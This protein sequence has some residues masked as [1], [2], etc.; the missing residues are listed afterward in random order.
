M[1]KFISTLLYCVCFLL[2]IQNV[3]A[4]GIEFKTELLSDGITYK[5]SMKPSTTWTAPNNNTLGAQVTIVVQTGGFQMDNLTSINGVWDKL[6]TIV[7]PT[8]RP[9]KDYIVVYLTTS[10]ALPY[11]ANTEIP[12][13]TFQNT[14][15]CT[16]ILELIHNASD[17]FMP[18]NSQ[19]FNVGNYIS[20]RGGGGSS[21]NLWTGN[22]GA[23]ADCRPCKIEYKLTP[24]STG[25]YQV[26]MIPKTTWLGALAITATQQVTI[27]AP[28]G[29]FQAANLTSLVAGVNYSQSSRFNAPS[30]N[31]TKDYLLFT[32]NN[33]GTT[34]L[35]YT[36]NVEVPLF[37]FT[38]S[39]SCTSG[40]IELMNNLSDP[41]RL[42]NS[43][44]ANV[45]QQ[46]TTVGGGVDMPICLNTSYTAP[47]NKPP[48]TGTCLISNEIHMTI[49]PK[50]EV[51]VSV[52]TNTVCVGGNVTL[53]AT[54]TGG[55]GCSVQWQSSPQAPNNWIDVPSATAN[56]YTTP[57]LS[58]TLKYRTRLICSG[59]GC[60]N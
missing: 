35:T 49:V 55:I 21:N 4:Q 59:I 10:T 45:G 16:G 28:T 19:S 37:T 36:A 3:K 48:T 42:P 32:L 31:P 43:R 5:V 23:T 24:L 47:C 58:N 12:L 26:S 11:T 40:N 9:S 46:L 34:N 17:P 57:N 33:L 38:N 7:A 51:N 56:T 15:V 50:P 20:T 13:F 25:K 29:G 8:E 52:P 30:E 39:G 18:P 27:V 60:C 53:S 6:P 44:S 54:I 2:A 22:Y 1:K 41:F 14:G